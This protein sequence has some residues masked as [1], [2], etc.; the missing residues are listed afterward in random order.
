[1]V[2]VLSV[3]RSAYTDRKAAGAAHLK[4]MLQPMIDVDDAHIQDVLKRVSVN[5]SM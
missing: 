1:M 5:C 3:N 4:M 2:S